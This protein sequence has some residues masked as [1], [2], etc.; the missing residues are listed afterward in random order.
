ME[1]VGFG[2]TRVLTDSA[3]KISMGIGFSSF[4]FHSISVRRNLLD[5][6]VREMVLKSF[7]QAL[8]I[9]Y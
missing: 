9:R 4:P 8:R 1:L 5:M 6:I 3:R 2:N 7:V